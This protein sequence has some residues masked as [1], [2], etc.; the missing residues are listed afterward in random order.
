MQFALK[1]P[2]G[3]RIVRVRYVLGVLKFDHMYLPNVSS[4]DLKTP[5]LSWLRDRDLALANG[6][7][8]SYL[9]R[10]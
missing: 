8:G 9:I 6:H 10:N 7:I 2:L 3:S 4:D 1:L 5:A